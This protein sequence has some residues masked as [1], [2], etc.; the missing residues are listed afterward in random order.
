MDWGPTQTAM[1]ES[2]FLFLDLSFLICKMEARV[3]KCVT[4]THH[5]CNRNNKRQQH[6]GPSTGFSVLSVRW[7]DYADVQ[8]VL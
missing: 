2:Q 6:R 5:H 4:T 8:A 1:H 7:W 3:E